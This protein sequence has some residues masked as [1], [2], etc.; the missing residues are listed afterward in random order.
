[1][2]TQPDYPSAS[3]Y[4]GFNDASM[5]TAAVNTNSDSKYDSCSTRKRDVSPQQSRF[6]TDIKRRR[7]DGEN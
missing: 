3:W 6:D 1:M 2:I 5:D 7:G 4:S